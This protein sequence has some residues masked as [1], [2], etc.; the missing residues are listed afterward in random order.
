MKEFRPLVVGSV[1]TSFS[2]AALLGIGALVGAGSFGDTEARILLTTVVI[3][4][5]SMAM[6][7]Y[8]ALDGHRLAL[9]G[10]LGAA[11]SAAATM[12]ALAMVW[13]DDLGDTWQLMLSATIIAFTLAQA[14]LLIALVDGTGREGALVGTLATAG[15]VA[16]MLVGAVM[17]DEL[18]GGGFWRLLGVLAILDVLGSVTLIALGAFGRAVDRPGRTAPAAVPDDCAVDAALRTRVAAA[19]REQ[20]TTPARIVNA[21]VE[22]YLAR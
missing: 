22:A 13:G 17:N 2:I 16:L 11:V 21:A 5:E 12:A 9:V 20:G 18:P 1:I 10:W 19:A 6:L 3:G 4:I 8:L 14:S 7:C 15:V